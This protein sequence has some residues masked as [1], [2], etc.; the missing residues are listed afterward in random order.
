MVAQRFHGAMSAASCCA[1]CPTA[2]T[3]WQNCN[4]VRF[5]CGTR[6]PCPNSSVCCFPTVKDFQSNFPF[7]TNPHRWQT[8]ATSTISGNRLTNGNSSAGFNLNLISHVDICQIGCIKSGS[9]L[10]NLPLSRQAIPACL[11]PYPMA[12]DQSDLTPTTECADEWMSGWWCNSG[13]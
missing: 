11:L 6:R 8:K 9:H 13:N 3:M 1:T 7:K 12:I 10:H 5:V 2:W 4:G